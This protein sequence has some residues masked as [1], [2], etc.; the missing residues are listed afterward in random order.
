MSVKILGGL[1][2]GFSLAIEDQEKTRATSILLKRKIFDFRQNWDHFYFC[3]LCAGSGSVGIEA[4]SRGANQLLCID[5]DAKT[6]LSLK[7]KF[8]LIKQKFYEECSQRELLI[9][10]LEAENFL[11]DLEKY[12][13]KYSFLQKRWVLFI[14]PPYER[15]S[16]YQG[17]KESLQ[18]ESFFCE[19]WIESDNL[20]GLTKDSWPSS[21]GNYNRSRHY[22]HGD[23]YIIQ[24]VRN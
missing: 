4:W 20:K 22:Q 6:I 12:N 18:K 23:H 17:L 7:K 21:L 3:D 13:L 10:K 8:Q 11:K 15:L 9:L 24:Y 1:L 5:L 2:K 14:D 16:I 19:V